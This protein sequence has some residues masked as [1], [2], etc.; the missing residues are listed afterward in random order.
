MVSYFDLQD[1]LEDTEDEK[2]N[3]ENRLVKAFKNP[4]TKLYFMFVKSM[5]SIFDSFNTFLQSEQ[6]LIHVLH[7]S[8]LRLYRSLLCRFVLP[9][10]ISSSKDILLLSIYLDDPN[11]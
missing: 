4:I 3:R 8:T 5:N 7:Q 2:S 9:E 1:D 11:S 10:I 6:P